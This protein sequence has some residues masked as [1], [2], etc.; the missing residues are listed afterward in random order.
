M[1][2]HSETFEENQSTVVVLK[3]NRKRKEKQDTECVN[4]CE[5]MWGTFIKNRK[6]HV[7]PGHVALI[8]GHTAWVLPALV[9]FVL[10]RAR[11][12]VPPSEHPTHSP[13]QQFFGNLSLSHTSSLCAFLPAGCLMLLLLHLLSAQTVLWW[14][15]SFCPANNVTLVLARATV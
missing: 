1:L 10:S 2:I 12:S 6:S 3:K 4:V 11:S 15:S 9:R 7:S 5:L 14:N 13:L 8:W